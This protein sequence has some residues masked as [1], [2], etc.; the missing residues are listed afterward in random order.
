MPSV[1]PSV[2][3][4]SSAGVAD[5][6]FPS[7]KLAGFLTSS[8]V[9]EPVGATS[10]EVPFSVVSLLVVGAATVESVAFVPVV[11][12]TVSELALRLFVVDLKFD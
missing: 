12:L 7:T 9:S 4:D 1:L 10:F 5:V 11:P 2:A 6:S 8:F 3:A